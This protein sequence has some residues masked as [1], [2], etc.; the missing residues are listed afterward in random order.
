MAAQAILAGEFFLCRR[1]GPRV[2]D[3]DAQENNRTENAD[4]L[5]C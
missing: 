4:H 3:D 1:S 2:Q 5:F